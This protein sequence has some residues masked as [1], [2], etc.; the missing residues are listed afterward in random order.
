MLHFFEHFDIVL[1]S[2]AISARAISFSIYSS[3]PA[4]VPG[5]GRRGRGMVQSC[6]G[7]FSSR[8][9]SGS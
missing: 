9:A 4:L 6:D 7:T 1:H 5:L 3:T 8:A 2:R